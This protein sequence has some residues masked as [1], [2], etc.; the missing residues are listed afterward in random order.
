ML[1]RFLGI[2]I[3][4]GVAACATD[5]RPP[6]EPAPPPWNGESG[7]E[8]KPSTVVRKEGRFGPGDTLIEYDVRFSRTGVIAETVQTKTAYGGDLI[9]PEGTK[10]YAT[11]YT[12]FRSGTY[13]RTVNLQEENNP[14]E[15]CAVLPHGVG[16]KDDK[17][18]AVCLFWESESTARYIRTY[19][20]FPYK[21][22][23]FGAAG[24]PGPVPLIIEQDVDFGV[25]LKKQYR[26]RKI[27]RKGIQIDLVLTDGSGHSRLSSKLAKWDANGKAR[28]MTE[29]GTAEF[30]R[31]GDKKSEVVEV[32]FLS[33]PLTTTD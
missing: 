18:E 10:V 17:P 2:F 27:K 11:D 5:Y 31:I 1:K 21:P 15:W 26:I 32:K 29:F 16:G 30:T 22:L 25:Q 6:S 23:L 12:L 4:M 9:L 3:T 14:V 13:T 8:A 33:E 24:M 28:F 19:G 20:G 7:F